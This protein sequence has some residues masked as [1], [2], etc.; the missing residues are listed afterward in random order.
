MSPRLQNIY[1][2]TRIE[3]DEKNLGLISSKLLFSL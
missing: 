1:A 2:C 3:G